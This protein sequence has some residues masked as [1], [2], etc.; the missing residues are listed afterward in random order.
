MI[1]YDLVA[2]GDVWSYVP[3]IT[4]EQHNSDVRA[5]DSIHAAESISC[6]SHAFTS[7]DTLLQF[8]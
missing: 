2:L 6:Y 1:L 4:T 3:C 7:P 8:D 5:A